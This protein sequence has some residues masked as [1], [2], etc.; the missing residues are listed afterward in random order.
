MI[1]GSAEGTNDLVWRTQKWPKKVIAAISKYQ[2]RCSQRHRYSFLKPLRERGPEVQLGVWQERLSHS[3]Q[4]S[5]I[6]VGLKYWSLPQTQLEALPKRNI[7]SCHAYK[8]WNAEGSNTETQSRTVVS[9]SAVKCEHVLFW[10]LGWLRSAYYYNT[11]MWFWRT[12]MKHL[13]SC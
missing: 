6:I 7:H 10:W 12:L 3:S 8:C 4:S 9:G 11:H 13:F 1:Q 5:K 2:R